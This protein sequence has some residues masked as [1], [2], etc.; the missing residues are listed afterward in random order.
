MKAI[1]YSLIFL[2]V[3]SCGKFGEEGGDPYP[4]KQSSALLK[5]FYGSMSKMNVGVFY[6]PDAE[7]YTSDF[8]IGKKAW[9]ILEDNMRSLY[10]QRSQT[11]SFEI[12]KTLAEMTQIAP[13]GRSV[14]DSSS[15]RS[16][17]SSLGLG[18]SKGGNGEFTII[19]VKGTYQGNNNIIGVSITGTTTI[20]IFKDVIKSITSGQAQDTKTYTEQF[21]IVHEMGHALGMVNNGV[22][23][24][25][26]HHDAEHG[27]HCS[28]SD[29]VMNWVNEGGKEILD[30]AGR[31]ILS[32]RNTAFGPQCLDDVKHYNP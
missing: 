25:S 16:L 15:L 7:P 27:A 12:P 6:E 29:C 1:I 21:T 19:F 14:W 26:N 9:D 8:I 24:R 10:S 28:N 22:S 18:N 13:Q 5:V 31:F 23:V 30:F 11:V 4:T 20:A 17:G 3:I 2:L 32:G